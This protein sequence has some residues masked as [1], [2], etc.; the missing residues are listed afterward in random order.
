MKSNDLA[1]DGRKLK[2]KRQSA[3]KTQTEVAKF[4]N[5]TPQ[6]YG[7]MEKGGI[8]PNST[9]LAKL[10]LYFNCPVQDFFNIPE[11]FFVNI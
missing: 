8:N 1:F 6:S 11:K 4:L 2:E 10:C 9:N 7:D 5:I 3:Q